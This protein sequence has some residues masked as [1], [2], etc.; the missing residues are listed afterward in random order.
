MLSRNASP[1]PLPP[2]LRHQLDT[3]VQ[4]YNEGRG[5]V[6]QEA[7]RRTAAGLPTTPLQIRAFADGCYPTEIWSYLHSLGYERLYQQDLE[8]G[9]AVCTGPA[10]GSPRTVDGRGRSDG[11]GRTATA[12]TLVR[13]FLFIV[14]SLVGVMIF[15]ASRTPVER[16]SMRPVTPLV[17]AAPPTVP[18]PAADSRCRQAL[19]SD[20]TAWC[21]T[22]LT[23][24]RPPDPRPGPVGGEPACGGRLEARSATVRL[25]L[26][27]LLA[28]GAGETYAPSEA[29]RRCAVAAESAVPR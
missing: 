9:V 17:Q 19:V 21:E 1:E 13:D 24:V 3:L 2:R 14:A 20:T 5:P 7:V 23:G 29:R 4:A 6:E 16:E 26:D 28:Q 15:L 22:A 12:M 11:P 18:R 25:A 10:A 27:A 8:R